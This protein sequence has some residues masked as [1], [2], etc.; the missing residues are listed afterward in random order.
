MHS[1]D[2]RYIGPQIEYVDE[3]T[4]TTYFKDGRFHNDYINRL[5]ALITGYIKTQE[6]SGLTDIATLMRDEEFP[7]NLWVFFHSLPDVNYDIFCRAFEPR[8]QHSKTKAAEIAV[9]LLNTFSHHVEN[10]VLKDLLVAPIRH[11]RKPPGIKMILP[12]IVSTRSTPLLNA[13]FKKIEEVIEDGTLT[14]QQGDFLILARS[15]HGHSALANALTSI[16]GDKTEKI[17]LLNAFFV[18]IFEIKVGAGDREQFLMSMLGDSIAPDLIQKLIV[19]SELN[20]KKHD[21]QKV[22]FLSDVGTTNDFTDIIDLISGEKRLILQRLEGETMFSGPRS[23]VRSLADTS[24]DPIIHS[25]DEKK[26]KP[27]KD[28]EKSI[29]A[30]EQLTVVDSQRL[31]AHPQ[32]RALAVT[33]SLPTSSTPTPR[34]GNSMPES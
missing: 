17:Q 12:H 14:V 4:Q 15:E 19:F 29:G 25:E 11:L 16:G 13:Y 24:R 27:P 32:T 9:T 33:T 22:D 28:S 20:F 3:T 34:P 21:Y 7:H 23:A 26:Q 18:Y 2:M 31:F 8:Y 30:W 1:S 6:P 5:R 10:H